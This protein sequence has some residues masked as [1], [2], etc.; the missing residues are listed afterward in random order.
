MKN[1]ITCCHCGKKVKKNARIKTQHY[2]SSRACQQA[3][4]NQ[5]ERDKLQSQKSYREQRKLQKANWR[6]VR[7]IHEYQRHYRATHP[8][9]QATNRQT[10]GHRNRAMLNI[11]KTDA[12]LS[13]GQF[14]S[15]MYTIFPYRMDAKGNIVK[16][17]ALIVE[18]RSCQ[19]IQT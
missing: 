9:Y 7:P 18:I 5:W 2:C 11:V 4:K 3:R 13:V 19:G 10:Q 14:T 6:C 15:G 1:S 12:L 16:T 17:D 8:H